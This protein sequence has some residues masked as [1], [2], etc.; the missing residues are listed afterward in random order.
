MAIRTEP[1]VKVREIIKNTP[2]AIDADNNS[3]IGLVMVSNYGHKLARVT[4]PSEFLSEYTLDGM[5][6]PRD[7]DITFINAYYMS[8]FASLVISRSVNTT[9][10]QGLMYYSIEDDNVGRY[11]DTNKV[12]YKDGKFLNL[13]TE[14]SFEMTP[15]N[16]NGAFAFVVNGTVFYS[17][18]TKED[19]VVMYPAYSEYQSFIALSDFYY[20]YDNSTVTLDDLKESISEFKSSIYANLGSLDEIHVS[21]I[22]LTYEDPEVNTAISSITVDI[23]LYH[24]IGSLDIPTISTG[25][26]GSDAND[27]TMDAPQTPESEIDAKEIFSIYAD[28]NAV[29]DYL[30]VTLDS[31]ANSEVF[32]LIYDDENYQASLNPEATDDNEVNIY[33]DYLNSLGFPFTIDIRYNE[34]NRYEDDPYK[35]GTYNDLA[36]NRFGSGVN[37][38]EMGKTPYL[39]KAADQLGD[40]DQYPLAYMSCAGCTKLS[41]VKRMSYI[42][43]NNFWF[44]PIDVPK[45]YVTLGAIKNYFNA[46]A[47]DTSYVE[48]MGPFDKNQSLTGWINYIACSSLWYERLMANKANNDEFAPIYKENYGVLT[49]TNPVKMLTKSQRE[50]LLNLGRPVNYVNYNSRTKNYFLNDDWT[51]QSADNVMS[52]EQNRR[53]VNKINRDIKQNM[54]QFIGRQNNAITRSQVVD[55]VNYYMTNEIMTKSFAPEAYEVICNSKNNP[56]EVIRA[57]QL[58]LTLRVRLYASIKYIDVINEIYPIGV[59]FED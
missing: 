57:K 8:Y 3:D 43:Q 21:D 58:K 22:E 26:C 38:T 39:N 4:G 6:V 54:D 59:E 13:R 23:T 48:A 36:M 41:F 27:V 24:T 37:A 56:D 14:W 20:I 29:T 12:W 53:L 35:V 15:S 19:L 17:N 42:A 33:I 47:M 50:E 34:D 28:T 7:A 55:M 18:I 11:I 40:Q 51:H 32:E 9:A 30:K 25:Q 44:L 2:T 45:D 46:L 16:T 10:T 49:Y 5:T 1:Y 52:E 31:D